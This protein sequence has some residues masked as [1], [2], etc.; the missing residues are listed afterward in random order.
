MRESEMAR[1]YYET[2]PWY[3]SAR[4]RGKKS[5]FLYVSFLLGDCEAELLSSHDV[6]SRDSPEIYT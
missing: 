1:Y 4:A 3:M 6:I 2:M 5:P